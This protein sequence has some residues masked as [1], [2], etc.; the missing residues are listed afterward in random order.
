ML[1]VGGVYFGCKT[2]TKKPKKKTK[3]TTAE[4]LQLPHDDNDPGVW[5][6]LTQPL[7][8]GFGRTFL[9]NFNN[10]IVA[11]GELLINLVTISS[12]QRL[13]IMFYLHFRPE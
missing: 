7:T 11:V 12:K 5:T 13:S 1:V 9:V 8:R 3:K 2:E 6:L 4:V 10:R